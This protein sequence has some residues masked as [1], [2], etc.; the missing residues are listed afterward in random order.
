MLFKS[1]G[2]VHL[3]IFINTFIEEECVNVIVKSYIVRKYLYFEQ[4][5]LFL[6]FIFIKES[7]KKVL[8]QKNNMK[9]FNAH[10]K[11]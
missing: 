5:L 3:F 8:F 4:T 2:S 6:T 9:S 1:L 11:S 7:K 10:H